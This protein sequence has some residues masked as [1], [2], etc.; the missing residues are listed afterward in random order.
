MLPGLYSPSMVATALD[1]GHAPPEIAPV[2]GAELLGAWRAVRD[3]FEPNPIPI[4]IDD[5]PLR[6]VVE[7]ARRHRMMV[8]VSHRSAGE[9][10]AQLGLPYYGA[11]TDPESAPVR[12]S[13]AL[14]LHAHHAGKNLQ[15]WD[16]MLYLVPPP[17]ARRWEQS[18]GRQ[19]RQ[20]QDAPRVVVEYASVIPYHEAAIDRARAQARKISTANGN[21]T[22]LD[23][24][25]WR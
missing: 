14:S 2:E 4:W 15:A 6:E 13:M 7:R 5:S 25:D 21:R 20:G 8:W 22:K 19:H 23:L 10:L 1:T 12:Q 24:A 11:A 3:R 17:S 18:I 9:R 16:R